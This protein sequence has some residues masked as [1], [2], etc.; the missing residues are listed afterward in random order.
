MKIQVNFGDVQHSPAVVEY[1]ERQLGRAMKHLAERIT[2][3]EVHLRDENAAKAGVDKRVV[4]EARPAGLDP[5][6]VDQSGRDLYAVIKHA[7]EKLERA[8][9][10][11]LD[12]ARA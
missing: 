10:K 12:R 8:V 9:T 6:T 1:V 11:R 7:A 3:V 5:I 2:R 4:M